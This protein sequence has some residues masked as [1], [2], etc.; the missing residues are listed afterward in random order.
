MPVIESRYLAIRNGKIAVVIDQH[1]RQTPNRCAK[2]LQRARKSRSQLVCWNIVTAFE[3]SHGHTFRR[4]LGASEPDVAQDHRVTSSRC[5]VQ[6]ADF[7]AD[8]I[9]K[10]GFEDEAFTP[11]N[12]RPSEVV[13]RSGRTV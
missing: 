8:R 1:V 9:R 2:I 10:H 13:G 12:V 5:I 7:V 4:Q 11:I 3:N 6:K